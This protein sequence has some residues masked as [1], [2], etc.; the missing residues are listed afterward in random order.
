M[1][2]AAPIE[3]Q[4]QVAV[5]RRDDARRRPGSA[6]SACASSCA[7]AR[8]ALR[9]VARELER[10][11][12]RE[13][14]ERAGRRHFDGERRHLGDAGLPADRVGDRVVDLS[15]NVRIMNGYWPSRTAPIAA[16]RLKVCR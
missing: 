13:V 6:P 4:V 14:A 10:D 7:I 8:G 16:C 11:R 2:N 15:L 5:R 3:I 1:R 12:H 9:S